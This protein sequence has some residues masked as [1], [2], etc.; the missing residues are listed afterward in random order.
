MAFPVIAVLPAHIL[1]PLF[2]VPACVLFPAAD[3]Y[4]HR[5]LPRICFSFPVA[6]PC[7]FPFPSAAAFCSA[8]AVCRKTA[9]RSPLFF[10]AGSFSIHWPF[11]VRSWPSAEKLPLVPRC[12]SLRALFPFT[13]HFLFGHGRLPKTRRSKPAALRAAG[14]FPAYV[15]PRSRI[16]PGCGVYPHR[17]PC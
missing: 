4:S 5:R 3:V 15:I 11:F 12:F 7:D 6:F 9:S 17:I 8:A 13:D 14:S 1:L 16:L 2:V 10:V